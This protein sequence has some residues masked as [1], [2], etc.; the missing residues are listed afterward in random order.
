[1]EGKR[2]KRGKM[3]REEN[4][5]KRLKKGKIEGKRNLK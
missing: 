4:V 1:M 3:E 2:A 5:V